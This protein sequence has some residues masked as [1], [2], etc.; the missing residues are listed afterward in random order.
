MK[1]AL[2]LLMPA[3]LLLAIVAGCDEDESKPNFTRLRVT[4]DC[5]VVPMGVE[6]YAILSGGNES[7]DPLGGNNNL[8]VQWSFGD[9]GTGSTTLAYH[10]YFA[11]GEYTITVKGT[12]PDGNSTSATYPVIVLADSLV[13][14]A[15]S[16]FPDGNVS[17]ADTVRFD[18]AAFSCDIDY[19]TVLGDSVKME[20]TWEMGDVDD[21]IYKVVAPEFQYTTPGQ[22]EVTMTVFYPAWAVERKQKLMFE[23]V[24]VPVP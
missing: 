21:T 16:N 19:P 14:N 20:F 5:G 9:G 24:D 18:M 12:D 3:I 1:R 7:G 22:K 2:K 11:A 17:T 13:I 4:P 6:G 23:V 8:D 10:K 15:G